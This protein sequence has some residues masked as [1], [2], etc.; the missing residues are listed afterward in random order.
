MRRANV[1]PPERIDDQRGRLI[2]CRSAGLH[3][4]TWIDAF[5]CALRQLTPRMKASL[6]SSSS[7]Q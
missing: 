4:L 6:Q 2:A 3:A 5:D 7:T 1:C